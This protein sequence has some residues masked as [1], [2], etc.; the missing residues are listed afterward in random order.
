MTPR[1]P[2]THRLP[3]RLPE[4]A[5]GLLWISPWLAGALLFL[6]IPVAL[7]AYFSLTDYSLLEPPAPVGLANYAEISRDPLFYTALRNTLVYTLFSVS[8]GTIVSVALAVLLE[9]P[10]RA[11]GLVR[12]L[13]FL[14][15]LIPV[16]SASIGWM[17]LYSGQFGRFNTAL[18]AIGITGPDWLGN[19]AWAMPSLIFMSVWFIGSAVVINTA[20]LRDVPPTLY[21]AAAID[22]MTP[23]ARFRHITLP[24]ISPAVLFNAIMA[25]IW[26]L[27]VFA[28]PLIMTKGGPDNATLVYSMYVFKNAFEY[29]RMGYASALAAIQFAITLAITALALLAARRFV[30]YRAA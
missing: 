16:V 25:T 5:H 4:W 30:H 20:A 15:T 12:A 14:P 27:Q 2:H 13:V 10:L 11:R 8:L 22:G 18:A 29:G 21:E 19:K 6:L 28:I 23:A 1:P 26:S 17:W 7:A 3:R 9:Q 24:M